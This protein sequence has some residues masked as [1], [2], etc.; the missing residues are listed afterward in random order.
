[1][2]RQFLDA[3]IAVA[4]VDVGESYGNPEGRA[5]YSA[6][7]E[8][9]TSEQGFDSKACLLARSR[10][11]LMVYAW[12]ADNPEKVRCI[13]GIYPVCN[14]ASYPGLD[15][16]CGA[17]GMSEEELAAVLSDHNPVDRAAP[18]AEAGIPVYHI[19]GNVDE[20][21][22]LEANSQLLAERLRAAGG[23]ME[24]NVAANQ[25]HNMWRGFFE[26]QPLVDFVIGRAVGESAQ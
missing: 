1:M 5:V 23:A 6:L 19:H 22:P 14:L 9:L 25:G 8:R 13:A 18:L 11:G 16:A 7:H 12:A 15:R 3:G 4:G 20:V 10:G 21:V 17:Y 24:I 2:F 26:C